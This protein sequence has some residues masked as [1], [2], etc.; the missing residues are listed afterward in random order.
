MGGNG[1]KWGVLAVEEGVEGVGIT[2]GGADILSPEADRLGG[3][4]Q[5]ERARESGSCFFG[6]VSGLL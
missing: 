5:S 6:L 4:R 1:R 2:V 3:S